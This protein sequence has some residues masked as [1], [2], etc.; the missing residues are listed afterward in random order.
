MALAMAR[1]SLPQRTV[2][3]SL[4]L[5]GGTLLH[6]A[7]VE[8]LRRLTL[9]VALAL[10][11]RRGLRPFLSAIGDRAHVVH[12]LGPTP[13]LLFLLL[14]VHRDTSASQIG[15]PPCQRGSRR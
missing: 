10:L 6:R 2:R 4:L 13:L 1:T 7:F 8:M 12:L 9:R 14:P 5:V 11:H 3:E 15:Q